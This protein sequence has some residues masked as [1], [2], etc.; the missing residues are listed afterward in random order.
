MPPWARRSSPSRAQ[1]ELE[2]PDTPQ[3]HSLRQ[4][5]LSLW[6]AW[7]SRHGRAGLLLLLLLL[8]G[9]WL[10]TDPADVRAAR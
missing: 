3:H 6:L 5:R 8:V 10:L 9:F 2:E 4:Q 7:L 1:T